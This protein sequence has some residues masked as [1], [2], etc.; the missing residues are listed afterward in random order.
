VSPDFAELWERRVPPQPAPV[1]RTF[2]HPDIGPITLDCDILTV[3]D[4]DL[5]LLVY[6]AAPGTTAAGQVE[7]LATIGVQQFT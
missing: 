6:T 2:L 4:S 1:S 3:R 7:L 5:R